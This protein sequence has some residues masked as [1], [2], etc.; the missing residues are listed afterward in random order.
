MQKSQKDSSITILHG[1]VDAVE[2]A[3]PDCL[4]FNKE[5]SFVDTA[6]SVSLSSLE[7][8]VKEAQS[9]FRIAE[10][11]AQKDNPPEK[12]T[13]FVD[14]AK[15][16][17]ESLTEALS[18]AKKE[19][20]KCAQLYGE[21]PKTQ[22]P[23]DFF[24]LINNFSKNFEHAAEQLK[25]KRTV[26][27]EKTK[28]LVIQKKAPAGTKDEKQN[29]VMKELQNRLSRQSNKVQSSQIEHGDLERM[30]ISKYNNYYLSHW[31]II[32]LNVSFSDLKDGFVANGSSPAGAQLRR[33]VRPPPRQSQNGISSTQESPHTPY[34]E[35]CRERQA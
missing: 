35:V 15:P 17:V 6:C 28:P 14:E 2:Q 21:D 33:A 18:V 13:K 31:G 5:L 10:T 16:R 19:F 24:A 25:K 27:E 7:M 1:L 12:L 4:D 3:R 8:M 9:S 23:E 11:E 26:Q 20:S 29:G 30:M 22:S 32:L 34:R